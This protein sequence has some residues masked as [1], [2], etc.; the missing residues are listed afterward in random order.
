MTSTIKPV[1]LFV[2]AL[3]LTACEADSDFVDRLLADYSGNRP[4]AAVMI[5]KDGEI[6]LDKT[7]GLADVEAVIPVTDS[8]NFRLASVTKAF[9]AMSI[10]QLIDADKLGFETRLTDIFPNFPPYGAAISIRQLL[11]HTSGLLPY[12]DLM[13]DTTSIQVLD[14]DVLEMM[15]A[16]DSTLFTPGTQYRYSNTGY[17]VLAQIVESISGQ[18]F[19]AY[20]ESHIFAPLGM[21]G[22]IAYL[23]GD[24]SFPNRAYGYYVV[25]DSV[26]F[27]D[28]SPTSAVLGDGGIYSS[29]RDMFL[30]DQALYTD[31]L[32]SSAL[33]DSAFTPWLD[34]YGC[35]WRIDSYRGHRRIHHTGSTCGFR[36]V[37]QRFPADHFTVIILTNRREPG[38]QPLAEQLVNHFLLK[39]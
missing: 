19:P 8:T 30:W 11:H 17:A 21:T 12:E 39:D 25:G 1:F 14:R 22:S 13:S 33:M 7:Y 18:I 31:N 38:V 26:F 16:Q 10:L 35:G 2:I 32:V 3:F 27:S 36:N 5:I 37:I 20:L 6:L 28:Q 9:T 15:Q 23:K 34:I 4:G 29:T 24:D